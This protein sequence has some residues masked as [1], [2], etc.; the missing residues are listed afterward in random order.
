MKS[1]AER[2]DLTDPLDVI[3]LKAFALNPQGN[4]LKAV[5]DELDRARVTFNH[6]DSS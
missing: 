1:E 5:I 2:C 6:L 4:T 3:P